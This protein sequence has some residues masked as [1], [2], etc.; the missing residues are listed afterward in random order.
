MSTTIT[1]SER[2]LIEGLPKLPALAGVRATNVWIIEWLSPGEKRTGNELH[3]WM[4]SQRPGWSVY[5]R[6]ESKTEVVRS[7][8]HAA[9]LAK[10]SGKVPI[11]HIE[12]HGCDMGIA[13]SND[14]R[15]DFLSWSELTIPLQQLNVAT[16]CNLIVVVAACFGFA[17]IQALTKGPRA[18][19][20]ALVGPNATLSGNELLLGAKEFYRRF[21]DE[22]PRLVDIAESAS[23]EMTSAGFEW[24]PFATMAYE[25]LVE[26]L[27]TAKRP[28][29]RYAR[30]E[31]L[32]ERMRKKTTF[33]P[34]EIEA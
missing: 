16:N 14:P 31:R 19:A 32:R 29:E 4:Q 23:R 11:L 8:E 7:I 3:I 25:A 22:R 30:L 20:V 24:E 10:R 12:A 9:G 5:D 17:A 2:V 18:P 33:S 1:D 15:G 13:S 28:A 34:E 21:S 27:I 26:Q 6:C